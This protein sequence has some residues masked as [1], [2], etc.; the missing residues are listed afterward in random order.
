MKMRATS[1]V[2]FCSEERGMTHWMTASGG[3]GGRVLGSPKTAAAICRI[4]SQK[5]VWLVF[6]SLEFL[7]Q[8]SC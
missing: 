3:R 1:S 2:A 4:R 8:L 7:V 6:K 5:Y